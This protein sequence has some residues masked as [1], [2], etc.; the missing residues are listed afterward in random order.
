MSVGVLVVVEQLD[1]SRDLAGQGDLLQRRMPEM[2]ENQTEV[3][4]RQFHCQQR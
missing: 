3:S 2:L 1:R 4:I